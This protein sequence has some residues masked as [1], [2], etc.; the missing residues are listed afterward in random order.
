MNLFN[1]LG[2]VYRD[3][4]PLDKFLVLL[5]TVSSGITAS[6]NSWLGLA[7]SVATLLVLLSRLFF[8]W[9]QFLTGK[10]PDEPQ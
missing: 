4:P 1:L 8:M 6:H 5:G 2:N 10:G 7:I 9:H 3:F